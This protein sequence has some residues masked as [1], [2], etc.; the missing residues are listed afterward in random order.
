MISNDGKDDRTSPLAFLDSEVGSDT[1][2]SS[3]LKVRAHTLY[4][5][6]D[7][8]LSDVQVTNTLINGLRYRGH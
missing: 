5:L 6:S 2:I 7:E 8:A 1:L 4:R 3:L